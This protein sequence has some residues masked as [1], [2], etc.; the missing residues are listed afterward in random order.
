MVFPKYPET[1]WSFKYALK[2][3]RKKATNPPLGLLTVASLLP[4][5]WN[6]KLVDLN[7]GRLKDKHLRWADLVMI[8]AASIQR[9]SVDDVINRCKR[10]KKRI[11]A[12][13]PLFTANPN[14]FPRIDHLVLNEAEVTL[15]L[16]LD[17]F[18]QDRAQHLYTSPE[19]ADISRT[20]IPAWDLIKIKHYACMG[21]QYSR[22]CPHDCEFCDIPMLYG[23]RPRVK[24]AYQVIAELQALYEKGWRSSVFFVDDNFIGNKRTLKQNILPEIASW[25]ESRRRPF[26]FLTQASIDIAD[27][28]ELLQLMVKAGFDTVFVGIETPNEKSLGECHKSHNM[29]RDLIACVNKIQQAG[30]QVQGGFIVGFDSD[31]L[32]IFDSQIDFIQQSGI[33]TAMV[34]LLNAMRGTKLYSRL[35]EEDRL[36]KNDS[37]DNTNGTLN[38]KPRMNRQTLLRGYKDII[39]TIYSPDRYYARVKTFLE[40]F[41]PPRRQVTKV[42]WNEIKAFVL[43]IFVLGV[44]EKERFH[45]WRLFLWSMVRRPRLFPLAIT[46]AIYGFHFRKV[47]EKVG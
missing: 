46:F 44:K 43:S 16:F 23:H 8:S 19:W 20:P 24:Y 30:M 33:V 39:R 6:K 28:D 37:G 22:G 12:G 34:G 2:F 42:H 11:V 7:V 27:D 17:D 14:Q 4:Q 47:F 18:R 21:I 15:P 1:F 26:T 45:Y 5:D 3:I 32:S 10:L 29:N 25:M 40:N 36:L 13:G 35:L 9:K 38:F 31:P 41:R